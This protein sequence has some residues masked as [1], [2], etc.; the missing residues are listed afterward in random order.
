MGVED[1][2]WWKEAQKERARRESSI[3]VSG[4]G[5][6]KSSSGLSKG[7]KWGP[8]GA[9]VDSITDRT[10]DQNF[11]GAVDSQLSENHLRPTSA[12]E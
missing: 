4:A 5:S 12:M 1:G 7:L 6:S 11:T 8:F 10:I 3:G 9:Q 2:D